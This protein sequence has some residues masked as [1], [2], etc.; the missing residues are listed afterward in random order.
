MNQIHF[1]LPFGFYSWKFH[2]HRMTFYITTT[3]LSFCFSKSF[4]CKLNSKMLLFCFD[5]VARPQLMRI[6]Q[7]WIVYFYQSLFLVRILWAW[8]ISACNVIHKYVNFEHVFFV[9]MKISRGD[10]LRQMLYV[11]AYIYTQIPTSK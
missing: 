8:K 9:C 6:L 11:F 2:S 4:A 3:I 7:N 1:P 10:F 5:V